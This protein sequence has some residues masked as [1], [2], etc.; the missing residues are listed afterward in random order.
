MQCLT[1]A[2]IQAVA[3]QEADDVARAHVA[4]CERCRARVE[5]QQQTMMN[6][7]N[8][9]HRRTLPPEAAA[10]V[11]DAIEAQSP[12]RGATSLRHAPSRHGART[13]GTA[14]AAAAL[15]A[16][17]VF[18]VLPR[19]GSP[20]NLSASDVLGRS[21]QTIAG[22]HGVEFVTYEVNARGIPLVSNGLHR[23]EE[24]TDHTRRNRYRMSAFGP[25]GVVE[26]AISQD[27]D[28]QRRT[29]LTRVDGKNFI[30]HVTAVTTPALSLPEVLQAYVESTIKLMQVSGDQTLHVVDT[31]DGP[32]YVIEMP[33]LPTSAAPIAVDHAKAI[34]DGREFRIREFHASGSFVDEPYEIDLKLLRRV[35]LGTEV[36]AT[37]FAIQAG[38]D[39]VVL[40]GPAGADPVLDLPAIVFRELERVRAQ[41]LPSQ[42]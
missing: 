3:D 6:L 12:V 28:A 20:T 26:H 34:I 5:A 42:P 36:A 15:I 11:R 35:A 31:P 8:A 19:L 29:V 7:A 25:D 14:A 13:W 17:V 9:L 24:L 18:G 40:E 10:R 30:V 22:Q 39:D 21:L 4:G 1:D 23:I 37:A 38:P 2:Q 32:Q 41:A 27:P 33:R 16:A